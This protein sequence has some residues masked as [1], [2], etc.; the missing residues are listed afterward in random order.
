M[1]I[2]FQQQLNEELLRSEKRR[3]IIIISIFL[4]MLGY[5]T[6]QGYFFEMDKETR[7]IQ[8]IPVVWLFPMV[9]IVFEFLTLFAINRQIRAKR[10]KLSPARQ[11]LNTAVEIFLPSFIFMTVA[12]QFPS[13]D[14][15]RSPALLVYFVFII[16]STMRL[17]FML[18]FFCG[19]LSG[20]SH[21]MLCFFIYDHFDFND[22]AR[23]SIILISSIAAGL[24]ANQIR[25]GINNSLKETEKRNKVENL[26]G[27]QISMEVAEKILE[28]N[29][30][31]ESKRMTVAIMF[32]DIRNF[33]IFAASRSPEEIVQYQN[34][35]F[36][37]VSDAVANHGGIVNQFLG[38]GCMVTFGAPVSLDNPSLHAVKAAVEIHQKLET[39]ILHGQ[40]VNTLI[41]IGIHTGSAITG[42]I[43]NNTRLQYSVTGKVVIIAARVEQLNKEFNS[44]I[45]ITN[46]VYKN[47]GAY[48]PP[49]TEN[50][51]SVSLKGFE[52]NFIIHRVA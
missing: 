29:G 1:K 33:T 14:V 24:V 11:Y 22:A 43:G 48:L 10:N 8:S 27:Q 35:F 18:S 41:G 44:Q 47:A 6:L 20:I 30:Q 9:V 3:T 52:E 31:I 38:D 36:A 19:V 26:F 12:R 4:F 51:G 49:A 17:N 21:F 50:L 32:V 42:N 37:I 28:N 7:T 13:F 25:R 23:T 34:T 2:H 5:R 16:L 40:I 39:A 15:L 45:L 46:D